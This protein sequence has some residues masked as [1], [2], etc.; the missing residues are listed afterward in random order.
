MV[1]AGRWTAREKL[2]RAPE[3]LSILR[4][5]GDVLEPQ[6]EFQPVVRPQTLGVAVDEREGT[7]RNVV[8]A[9][10]VMISAGGAC[11]HVRGVALVES[12][13]LR[14]RIAKELRH[15]KREQCALA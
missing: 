2:E 7:K 11:E 4:K 3:R 8:E 9:E 12:E 10:I 6:Q 15:Q 1:R 13:H 5:Q 14:I